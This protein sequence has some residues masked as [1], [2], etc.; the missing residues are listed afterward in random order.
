MVTRQERK[1][2]IESFFQ[3]LT[4]KELD[5]MLERNGINYVETKEAFDKELCEDK[6]CLHNKEKASSFYRE[7]G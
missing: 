3:N 2:R 5:E 7:R 6:E 4:P 1:E